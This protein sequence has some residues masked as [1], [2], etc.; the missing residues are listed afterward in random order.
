[1][2]SVLRQKVDFVSEG[3]PLLLIDDFSVL[4]AIELNANGLLCGGFSPGVPD[5]ARLRLVPEELIIA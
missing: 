5:L 4:Q 2:I 1:M 3:L